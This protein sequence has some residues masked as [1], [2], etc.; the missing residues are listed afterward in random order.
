MHFHIEHV[1]SSDPPCFLRATQGI[2]IPV[3]F[4]NGQWDEY[5]VASDARHFAGAIA[6]SQFVSLENAG[7]SLDMEHKTAS[8][9][10]KNA[11]LDFLQPT[12]LQ[13]PSL[14]L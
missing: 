9:I 10:S 14:S 8:H 7:H 12:S 13:P 3:L 5:T 1:L 2:E 11:L 4:I 6:N